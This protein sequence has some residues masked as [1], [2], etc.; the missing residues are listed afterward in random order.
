MY[1]HVGP[2]RAFKRS[3]VFVHVVVFVIG[4]VLGKKNEQLKSVLMLK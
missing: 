3:A 1:L 4:A 2:A